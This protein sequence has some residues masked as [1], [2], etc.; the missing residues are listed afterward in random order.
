[1]IQAAMASSCSV[2]VASIEFNAV[3]GC[4]FALPEG[5]VVRKVFAN[6]LPHG[7]KGDRQET[8][9]KVWPV[10]DHLMVEKPLR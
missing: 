7:G 6:R 4:P 2:D 3:V 8:T 5:P 9:Q 10:A 1:M